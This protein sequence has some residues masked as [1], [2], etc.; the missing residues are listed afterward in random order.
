[1]PGQVKGFRKKDLEDL[2][3]AKDNSRQNGFFRR[4]FVIIAYNLFNNLL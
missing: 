1:M 3:E 4:A 2:R